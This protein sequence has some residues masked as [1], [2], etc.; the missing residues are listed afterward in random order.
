MTLT[1]AQLETYRHEA[2]MQ[3]LEGRPLITVDA[4]NLLEMLNEISKLRLEC[5]QSAEKIAGLRES[6]LM[7]DAA[8]NKS[9]L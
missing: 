4:N 6:N 8:F 5:E 2:T 9:G 7:A 1:P 3:L